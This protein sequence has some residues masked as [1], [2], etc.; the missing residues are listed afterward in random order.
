M[1]LSQTGHC[2]NEKTELIKNLWKDGASIVKISDILHMD[3]KTVSYCLKANGITQEEIY[4]RRAKN[5][6][7]YSSKAVIRY[8][9]DGEFLDE[10]P[11]ASL[12]GK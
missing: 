4:K 12:A 3:C 10:W 1:V 7:I 11:S 9:L 8:S 5:T 2:D 6:G